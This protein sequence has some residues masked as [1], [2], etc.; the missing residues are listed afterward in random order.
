MSFATLVLALASHAHAALIT[1]EGQDVVYRVDTAASWMS[2]LTAYVDGNSLKFKATSGQPAVDLSGSPLDRNEQTMYQ[3]DSNYGDISVE[4]KAGRRL[5]EF[6]AWQNVTHELNATGDNWGAAQTWSHAYLFAYIAPDQQIAHS[7]NLS[8]TIAEAD[9]TQPEGQQQW[10]N[11]SGGYVT[12]FSAGVNDV[13]L[14][15]LQLVFSH[16]AFLNSALGMMASWNHLDP[17]STARVTISEF[18]IGMQVAPV[19]EPETYALMGL[20]LAALVAARRRKAG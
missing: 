1:L 16:E 9:R 7:E 3:M 19:P 13:P 12:S 14:S 17:S 2:N 10:Q 8:W 20:G 18:G 4:A 5:G 15:A 11:R 6:S